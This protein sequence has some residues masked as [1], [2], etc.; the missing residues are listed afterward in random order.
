MVQ[1][2][3]VVNLRTGTSQAIVWLSPQ[4]IDFHSRLNITVNGHHVNSQGPMVKPNLHTLLEDVRTRGDR[5]HPFWAKIEVPG[6]R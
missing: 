5:Q 2:G 1:P 4:M 6:G 3:N